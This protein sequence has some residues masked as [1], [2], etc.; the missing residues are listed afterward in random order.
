MCHG[1]RRPSQEIRGETDRQTDAQRD[2]VQLR[3]PLAQQSPFPSYHRN[4]QKPQTAKVQSVRL[5]A[6]YGL[7]FVSTVSEAKTWSKKFV[8]NK[9][10]LH[11]R[12]YFRSQEP[13]QELT[14][15]THFQTA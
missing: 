13:F 8:E 6:H 4:L 11:H 2:K 9:V 15:F 14:N 3:M 5:H 1:R 7:I 12:K 10:L